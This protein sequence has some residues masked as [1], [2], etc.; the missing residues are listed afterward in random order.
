MDTKLNDE[1]KEIRLQA[2]RVLNEHFKH[3]G[4]LGHLEDRQVKLVLDAMIE[5]KQTQST[6]EN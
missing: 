3:E 4:K 6:K 1:D 5:F 2:L